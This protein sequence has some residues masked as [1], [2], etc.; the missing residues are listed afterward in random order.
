M[1]GSGPW[2]GDKLRGW[3]QENAFDLMH[4]D[5][6]FFPYDPLGDPLLERLSQCQG[7]PKEYMFTG[8]GVSQLCHSILN[9]PN[10]SSITMLWPEFGLYKFIAK[11]ARRPVRIVPV[12]R[13]DDIP[14]QLEGLE[15]VPTDLL[16]FSSPRWYTG[17]EVSA[18]AIDRI[19]DVFK[20]VVLLDQTYI[21]FSDSP[22]MRVKYLDHPRVITLRSLSKGFWLPGLRV[23]YAVSSVLPR[24]F[25]Y[26]GVPPHS[27][28]SLSARLAM[29]ILETPEVLR[30]LEKARFFTRTLRSHI[31]GKLEQIP[32]LTVVPSQ[33]VLGTVFWADK[34]EEKPFPKGH[35]YQPVRW[36]RR[37]LRFMFSNVEAANELLEAIRGTVE[38]GIRS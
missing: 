35:F 34:R 6:N 25:R 14:A 13:A 5:M 24:L 22:V 32:S 33:S 12:W 29:R 37:G 21:D 4:L 36:P 38:G 23:G 19:L 17:E 8:A 11:T 3:L 26:G 18:E 30:E 15:S 7:V 31:L 20:G 1:R 16:V 28:S 10:W 9:L 27:V 2:K